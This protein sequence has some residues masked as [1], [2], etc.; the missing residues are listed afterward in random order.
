MNPLRALQDSMKI[1]RAAKEVFAALKK[2]RPKHLEMGRDEEIEA[3]FARVLRDHPET[4]IVRTDQSLTLCFRDD[5]DPFVSPDTK[6]AL[7][8]S[9]M[10]INKDN[11]RG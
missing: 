6:K 7:S 9:G 1:R 4:T 5:I 2:N 3:V 8:E 11:K 10:V